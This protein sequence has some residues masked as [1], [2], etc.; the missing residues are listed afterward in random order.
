M[1]RQKKD[2]LAAYVQLRSSATD[3]NLPRL[4]EEMRKVEREIARLQSLLANERATAILHDEGLLFA[5][6]YTRVQAHQELANL[7]QQPWLKAVAIAPDG[8]SVRLAARLRHSEDTFVLSM[9]APGAPAIEILQPQA[10]AR[11]VTSLFQAVLDGLFADGRL[12]EM[13]SFCAL[14][15]GFELDQRDYPP[16]QPPAELER[17]YFRL[18]AS[19]LNRIASPFPVIADPS[20]I[21]DRLNSLHRDLCV[22]DQQVKELS[23]QANAATLRQRFEQEYA[24]LVALPQVQAFLVT[25]LQVE[26]TTDDIY[27]QNVLLV[28]FKVAYDFDRKRMEILNQTRPRFDYDEEIRFDHPHVRQGNP[29][30]GNIQL[31]VADMLASRDVPRLVPLTLDFLKS[32]NPSNPHRRIEEWM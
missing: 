28:S 2:Q 31:A 4:K 13:V 10:L 30:L 21:L 7:A 25:D 18:R 11:Q 8:K 26:F 19:W 16:Y 23:T 24:S 32:Y 27:V 3:Q 9:Q 12:A 6:A 5:W 15:L 29:C 1:P 22:L 20:G 17:T 14:R